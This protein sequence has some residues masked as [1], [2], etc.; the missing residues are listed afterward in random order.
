MTLDCLEYLGCEG[1]LI[2]VRAACHLVLRN[3]SSRQ[4]SSIHVLR[5]HQIRSPDHEYL[6]NLLANHAFWV[7]GDS[8]IHANAPC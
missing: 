5:Y 4:A 3:A 1:R 8:Y 7:E 6:Q 2:N